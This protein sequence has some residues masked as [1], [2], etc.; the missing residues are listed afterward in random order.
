MG[1]SAKYQK[2]GMFYSIRFNSKDL[3]ADTP[4][5]LLDKIKKE[6]ADYVQRNK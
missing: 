2:A 3:S 6:Y 4:A 1:N 5:M